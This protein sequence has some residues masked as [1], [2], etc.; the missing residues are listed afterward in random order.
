[1]SGVE[2]GGKAIEV[3][4]SLQQHFFFFYLVTDCSQV[5]A[6]QMKSDMKVHTK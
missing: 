6:W 2:T 5:L 1:M 4:C 3:E